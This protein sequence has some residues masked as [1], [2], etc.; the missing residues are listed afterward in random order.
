MS[1]PHPHT[2]SGRRRI[3]SRRR[4]IR[5]AWATTRL[6]LSFPGSLSSSIAAISAPV[7]LEPRI[8]GAK[9]DLSSFAPI[10]PDDPPSPASAPSPAFVPPFGIL[11]PSSPVFSLSICRFCLRACLPICFITRPLPNPLSLSRRRRIYSDLSRRHC[12]A[13]LPSLQSSSIPTTATPLRAFRTAA[14]HLSTPLSVLPVELLAPGRQ[15]SHPQASPPDTWF[16]NINSP[17][18]LRQAET[19][20]AGHHFQVI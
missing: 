5:A 18:D 12:T 20:L 14:D 6:S 4:P 15:V 1:P 17:Q 10:L 2:A 9:S 19:L 16:L 3:H 7:G 11:P 8:A 13:A